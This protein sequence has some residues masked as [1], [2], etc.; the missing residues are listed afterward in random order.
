MCVGSLCLIDREPRMLRSDEANLLEELAGVVV[1]TLIARRAAA[2]AIAAARVKS[3]FLASIGHEIRTPMTAILGYSEIITDPSFTA[4][5]RD[6]MLAGIQRNGRHLI[7]LI[8]DLLDFAGAE[9][10]RLPIRREPA[11]PAQVTR[12][13]VAALTPRARENGVTLR[14]RIEVP[15]DLR[16]T[17]DLTRLRQ[18][19]L[20]ITSVA[21]GLAQ[22]GCVDMHTR[23]M[24]GDGRALLVTTISIPG[25]RISPEDVD[26]FFEP[27]S[28]RAD[29]PG[30]GGVGLGLA[31][32]R[33]ISRLLG[34]DLE[35]V[36][37][38]GGAAFRITLRADPTTTSTAS[39]GAAPGTQPP[40]RIAG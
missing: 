22:S 9:S 12:E 27:F 30:R 1:E 18:V 8:N 19:L 26:R 21:I 17:T 11:S 35:L 15:D 37:S 14:P 33:R 38:P 6:E 5:E 28:D 36:T 4:A 20:N 29:A 23:M 16:I 13:I 34:G 2:D 24:P 31:L 32:S 7:R 40:L 39:T 25:G 3:T 10:G